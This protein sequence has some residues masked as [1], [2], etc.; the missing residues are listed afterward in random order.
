MHKAAKGSGL[1]YTIGLML[2][3]LCISV[4]S[5]DMATYYG[6]QNQMQTAANAASLAAAKQLVESPFDD[7]VDVQADAI[8]AAEEMLSENMGEN[9]TLDADDVVFGYVDP[10]VGSYDP[11]TYTVPSDNPALADNGGYN[12]ARVIV[13]RGEGSSN[14]GLPT[15]MAA[16]MGQ[17]EMAVVAAST[18]FMNVEL[19]EG[20]AVVEVDNPTGGLMPL[21]MCDDLW[22]VANQDG[23]PTN[24]TIGFFD[25]IGLAR[26]LAGL[27]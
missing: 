23:D 13:R 17:D 16:L 21:Y 18:S 25:A 2:L 20:E 10:E 14:A 22:T 8:A 4:L 9:M 11:N 12:S 6:Y 24:D 1:I 26:K 19:V 27:D 3:G 15:I 5:V 7:P